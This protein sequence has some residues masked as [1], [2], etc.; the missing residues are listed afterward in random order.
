LRLPLEV[1]TKTT[2]IA[3][4]REEL[5]PRER[6]LSE[7]ESSLLAREHGVVEGERALGRA[8]LECNAI[9]N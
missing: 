8:H 2:V 5:L 6:E 1:V 9:H 3:E 7:Q 4:L